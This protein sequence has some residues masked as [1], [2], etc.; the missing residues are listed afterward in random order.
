MKV[1]DLLSLDVESLALGGNALARVDGRVV[2]VDRGLPGD[3]V[4]AR[5]RRVKRGHAEAQLEAVVT[6]S[7]WRIEARCPHV[8]RCGGCRFQ[9][10][11]YEEQLRQKERQ[12]IETLRHLGGI[13]EPPVS[14]IRAAPETFGYRN[15]MEFSFAPAEDGT[16][17][18]GLHERGTFD[19]IFEIETC[20]L[21]GALTLEIVRLTQRFARE[22]HWRAYHPVR[23]EGVVRFLTV[24][25]LPLSGECA[26]HLI[27][28]SDQVSGLAEWARAVA[29]LS[30]EI[31]AVTLGI[32]RSRAN[33]ALCDEERVL[34]GRATIVERLLGLEFEAGVNAFLQTNSRQAEALYGAALECAGL[35]GDESVLDLYC[36]TGTL[37][38]LFARHAR[39]AVGV[40]SVPAAVE[41]AG[42]N[43]AR[44][45]IAGVRFECGEARAV[46][47]E[48]ARGERA[49]AVR[50]DI[51]VVDPPRAGLHPRVVARVAELAPRR[52]VYVSCNPATL[53]RDLK[54]FASG[55]YGLAEVRPFDMFPHTPHIECVARLERSA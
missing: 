38:L 52:I 1:N 18:L 42:R 49:G 12:V 39:E 14:R 30:D 2:F 46:L 28:A 11:A 36:G 4:T 41:A 13:A 17:R 7:P 40:E 20:L 45:G 37:T 53:A 54:D 34:E 15:K 10:L 51:V 55:G 50:P 32:S 48:W 44:N 19:R 29:T 16:P 43:A 35:A 24:R 47:R 31:K 5:L 3:R 33:V 23:H 22:H 21:P 25:H 8:A 9:D 26:V 27:A 6:R